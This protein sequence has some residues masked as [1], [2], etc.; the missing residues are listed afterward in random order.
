MQAIEYGWSSRR[1]LE[2]VQ[3]ARGEKR[4]G[5]GPKFKYKDLQRWTIEAQRYLGGL[6]EEVDPES[7]NGKL[8]L[9]RVLSTSRSNRKELIDLAAAAANVSALAGQ[10]A[11]RANRAGRQRRS[12]RPS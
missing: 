3:K 5:G 6:F 4:Q 9:E 11:E 7:G 2:E 12:K 10:L 8:V 1:L